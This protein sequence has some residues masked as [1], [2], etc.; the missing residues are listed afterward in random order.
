MNRQ[1]RRVPN[2]TKVIVGTTNELLDE[3]SR[4]VIPGRIYINQETEVAMV[5]LPN[6]TLKLLHTTDR[7]ENPGALSNPLISGPIR[8][9]AGTTVL[10]HASNSVQSFID[11]NTDI[12]YYWYIGHTLVHVGTAYPV[13]PVAPVGSTVTVGCRAIDDFNNTSELT[14][15]TLETGIAPVIK[16]FMHD[17]PKVTAY[18]DVGTFYIDPG[19]DQYGAP[20]TAVVSSNALLTITGVTTFGVTTWMNYI[21]TSDTNLYGD[22]HN[23]VELQLSGITTVNTEVN[24]YIGVE[25]NEAPNSSAITHTL[26]DPI[27]TDS[28]F[29]FSVDGGIDPEGQ[30][31]TYTVTSLDADVT[32]TDNVDVAGGATI[33]GTVISDPTIAPKSIAFS[34]IATDIMGAQSAA[35]TITTNVRT[36][37]NLVFDVTGFTHDLTN[38]ETTDVSSNHQVG[39]ITATVAGTVYSAKYRATATHATPPSGIIIKDTAYS[40]DWDSAG[41]SA[42]VITPFIGSLNASVININVSVLDS[43]Q[44]PD[45]TGITGIPNVIDPSIGFMATITGAVDPEGGS[46]N[47]TW[48]SSNPTCIPLAFPDGATIVNGERISLAATGSHV[49]CTSVLTVVG[50][51][52]VSGLSSTA[53]FS[54]D[55]NYVLQSPIL[56][57]ITGMPTGLLANTTECFTIAGAVDPEG[58]TVE[59]TLSKP[60]MSCINPSN[61]AINNG[62][63]IS[64]STT[65][66]LCTSSLIMTGRSLLTNL[67]TTRTFPITVSVEEAPDMTGIT[68]LPSGMG[69]ATTISPAIGGITDPEGGTVTYVITSGLTSC[70]NVPST[71]YNNGASP[72]FTSS[73]AGGCTAT[74]TLTA[75]SSATG[76]TAAV[77]FDIVVAA[78]DGLDLSNLS[79]IPPTMEVTEVFNGVVGGGIDAEGGTITYTIANSSTGCMTTPSSFTDGSSI[80]LTAGAASCASSSVAL[81]LVG[82]SSITGLQAQRVFNITVTGGAVLDASTMLITTA[83]SVS[84]TDEDVPF[85]VNGVLDASGGNNVT[86]NIVSVSPSQFNFTKTSVLLNNE[87]S[88]YDVTAIT[89]GTVTVGVKAYDGGGNHSSIK[90]KTVLVNDSPSATGVA[91]NIADPIVIGTN[92]NWSITGG[93]DA[94]GD[95]VKHTAEVSPSANVT[96]VGTKKASGTTRTFTA[97][98]S[99]R[100]IQITA[101]T[102]DQHGV[103]GSVSVSRN[104]VVGNSPPNMAGMSISGPTTLNTS[105]AGTY[106]FTAASDPDGDTLTYNVAEY[107]SMGSQTYSA[108]AGNNFTATAGGSAGAG[109]FTVTASD[110]DGATSTKS[111]PITVSNNSAPDMSGMTITGP[112]TLATSAG[113]TYSFTAASDPEGG[114]LTYNVT[115]NGAMGNQSYSASAGSNFTAT[116]SSSSGAGGFTVTATD[117]AGLSSTKSYGITVS[118]NGAPDMSGMTITGPSELY[119]DAGGTYSFTAASD[120]EGGSLTYSVTESGAMGTQSYSATAD[121]NFTATAG[122]SAGSG[123]FTVTA[124]DPGG[125]T[126]TKSFAITVQANGA[127]NTSGMT[128]TGPSELYVNSAGTFSFTAASDPD[129]DSLTYTVTESGAMG[130]ATYVVVPGNN[131]SALAGGSVGAGALIVTATDPGGLTASKSHAVDVQA[132]GAPNMDGMTIT[133]PSALQI[134]AS[135]TYTFTAASDPDGDTLTYTVSESGTMGIQSYSASAN[136]NFTAT[137]GN[138][139]GA[140]GFTV[141]ATDTG[142]LSGTKSFAISVIDNNAPNMSGSTITGPSSLQ[143]N[144]GGVY[145]FTAA[146]DP[147]GDI[148]TYTVTESG[149]MG[150]N[151]Y[152]ATANT[153]FTA[154]A[155]GSAGGG[156]FTVTASDPDGLTSSKSY[157]IAVVNNSAPDLTN[158][159]L[160]ADWELCEGGTIA[161]SGVSD[162]NGDSMTWTISSLTSPRPFSITSG[163]TPKSTNDTHTYVA[164]GSCSKFF[165][166]EIMEV[167]IEVT[168]VHGASTTKDL[169]YTP[170]T[171]PPVSLPCNTLLTPISD[172]LVGE[173]RNF[174]GNYPCAPHSDAIIRY[175]VIS[176]FTTMGLIDKPAGTP[177]TLTA[178]STGASGKIGVRGK[179]G[180]HLTSEIV[181]NINI[182]DSSEQWDYGSVSD[183]FYPEMNACDLEWQLTNTVG[184]SLWKADVHHD[185][186]CGAFSH[187]QHDTLQVIQDTELNGANPAV[188]S[189]VL[190]PRVVLPM[191]GGFSCHVNGKVVLCHLMPPND[192]TSSSATVLT[193]AFLDAGL[194]VLTA[195]HTSTMTNNKFDEADSWFI[196]DFEHVSMSPHSE[197]FIRTT[198]TFASGDVLDPSKQYVYHDPYNAVIEFDNPNW[199]GARHCGLDGGQ[200]ATPST[201]RFHVVTK[202]P[203]ETGNSHEVASP[204]VYRHITP[205]SVQIAGSYLSYSS[206][207]Y[208]VTINVAANG[209]TKTSLKSRYNSASGTSLRVSGNQWIWSLSSVS[210]AN[211]LSFSSSSYTSLNSDM[212]SWEPILNNTDT[213]SKHHLDVRWS[214]SVSVGHTVVTDVYLTNGLNGHKRL[215]TITWLAV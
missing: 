71:A 14:L 59:I 144:S 12:E 61:T 30:T 119:T 212:D 163:S 115:E 96:M 43:V 151:T 91:I 53:T 108:S 6:G 10:L 161:L 24:T 107:G 100:T 206:G 80:N 33:N 183:S 102:H 27:Y 84:G 83:S 184:R 153:N 174:Q 9:P 122:G 3:A 19:T 162:P 125:L 210:Y 128:I 154:T 181:Y 26:P 49:D 127:P 188:M 21:V 152:A 38:D 143:I 41:T 109:G 170:E 209:I 195:S 132:N 74:M 35:L 197:V 173:S 137:A 79:G 85:S 203:T 42:I 90:Y 36:N 113:G 126:A 208:H 172:L 156:G 7:P 118:S 28:N 196:L 124:T 11:P 95:T 105:D 114:L 129:G 98:G 180:T 123:G 67:Y 159:E 186:A 34:V 55:A 8:S 202:H 175:R 165:S 117:P 58:G 104:L 69:N 99:P 149:A 92:Y 214:S 32:L 145:S 5:Q 213:T 23:L 146:S 191:T 168:D 47:M 111:Y 116:A 185:S 140:G 66:T 103:G 112:T 78:S 192:F 13:I 75:T 177:L 88:P 93:T 120:P 106:S 150:T 72:T 207:D 57:G 68:G 198:T 215:V 193:E 56:T 130:M 205:T 17:L 51:S 169:Q 62:G 31:M 65:S 190:A 50:V 178:Q 201:D 187:S 138:T 139:A 194:T 60:A 44:P 211:L 82:T 160:T 179:V 86:Y 148:L 70:V 45:L 63:C 155:G 142:G 97:T 199:I 94:N 147:D 4:G 166:G 134:G 171:D 25:N 189:M 157:Y 76:L 133:G 52:S 37:P 164:Y 182:V 121:N 87:Q 136:T 73:A 167:R 89:S 158:A 48:T 77:D 2:G 200:T 141:T 135:G 54:V 29:T 110:P 64:I 16:P 39:G 131:F 40:W 20:Y 22:T 18:G 204:S 1:H 101:Y 81:T 15:F 46:I 176:G